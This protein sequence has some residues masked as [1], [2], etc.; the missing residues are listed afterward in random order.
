L[1]KLGDR[2]AERFVA[3][4]SPDAARAMKITQLEVERQF[5]RE[6]ARMKRAMR[7]DSMKQVK[8]MAIDNGLP[9][10]AISLLE[11]GQA[12]A[13]AALEAKRPPDWWPRRWDETQRGLKAFL[14]G[15]WSDRALALGWSPEELYRPP[16]SLR[17]ANRVGLAFLIGDGR[18]M[19][20][21]EESITVE[22]PEVWI[23]G[24][25]YG[26]QRYS[27]GRRG[28]EYFS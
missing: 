21:T 20:V 2:E 4:A 6:V 26:L 3:Q 15:G 27:F 14:E 1:T 18:V 17:G 9:L 16:R 7:K 28:R 19:A 12:A 24:Q 22:E 11:A 5:R 10:Y 25:Q 8:M 23:K 13:H